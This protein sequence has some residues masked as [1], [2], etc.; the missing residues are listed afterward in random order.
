MD[1]KIT[2]TTTPVP[3]AMLQPGESLIS[4]AGE[5]DL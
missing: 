1:V 4:E 3:E 2:G 5:P